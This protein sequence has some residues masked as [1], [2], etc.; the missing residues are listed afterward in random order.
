MKSPY[1]GLWLLL[2]I[3]LAIILIFSFC[4]D[5]KIGEW[6][7]KKAPFSET[8]FKSRIED[9]TNSYLNS[10]SLMQK[11]NKEV[12]TDSTPQSILLFGDSMTMNLAL[13]LAQYAE[14]NGHKFHAVNWDSSNTISWA[15]CDT[16]D[17]YIS[18][19]KPTYIFVSLGANELYLANPDGHRKYVESI[20]KKIGDIPFVWI[21]PP[22]WKED[23]GLNDMIEDVCTSG[24]F[25]RSAG[26]EFERKKDK[27][28]PTRKASALW[29]DSIARWMPKSSHPI[30][31]SLPPD[32]IKVPN[33]SITFLKAYKK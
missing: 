33:N 15:K 17:N 25:F 9:N 14:H 13:R 27:V 18:R 8:L 3:S 12:V 28:H 21:G 22:N 19:F 5:I 31:L 29:I 20:I 30:I 2:S 7:V 26:M 16:L 10:D 4:D 1:I 23:N 24:N 32:S 6:E 11:K